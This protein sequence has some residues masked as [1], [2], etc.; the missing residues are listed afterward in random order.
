VGLHFREQLLVHPVGRAPQSELTQRGQVGRREEVLERALGLLGDVDLPFLQSLDQIV[1]RQVD[2]LDGIGSIEHGIRHRLA[3]AHMRDLRDYVI[4]A[5]D[6]L[7]VDGRVDVDAVT[8]QFF[9]VEIAFGVAAAFD[10]GVC[11]FIDQDD[12]WPAGDDGVE[13]H[14]LERLL[15]ILDVSARNDFQACQQRYGIFAA[16]GLD[17]AGDD[18]I[19]VF[20][21]GMRLVQHLVGLTDTWCSAD[22]N[23]ELADAA[24]FA[25][26][27]FEQGF[28]RRPVLGSA[29]LIRHH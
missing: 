20:L 8:H 29:P 9:D 15:F 19:P 28:R 2:Q 10:V 24:F 25:A 18:V 6:V 27:R 21:A 1:G 14:F 7:D 5:L 13:V 4:E 3:H 11:E 17:D 23:S 12:L 22:E 26:R 16:M